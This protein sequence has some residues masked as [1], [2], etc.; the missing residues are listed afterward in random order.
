MSMPLEAATDMLRPAYD[1]ERLTPVMSISS[2]IWLEEDAVSGNAAES[3][4]RTEGAVSDRVP[5]SS[6]CNAAKISRESCAL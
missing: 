6:S 1:S 2:D 3:V 4:M 5:L